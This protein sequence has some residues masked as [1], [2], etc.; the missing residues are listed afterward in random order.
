VPV[1]DTSLGPQDS[2]ISAAH[3][4]ASWARARRANWTSAPV[5]FETVPDPLVLRPLVSDTPVSDPVVSDPGVPA[6]VIEAPAPD[7]LVQ[8]PAKP[9]FAL[10]A[11]PRWLTRGAVAAALLAA[12]VVG[13]RFLW[14]AM[15][16]RPARTAVVEPAKVTP[17][18]TVSA[19]GSLRVTST[20]SG[21]R[22]LV[23][24]KPRGV[25]PLSLTDLSPGRHEVMLQSDVGSVKRTVT[26]ATTAATVVDEAIFSG[27][28]T[29]YAP[30]DVTVSEKG[31]VLRAD[32]RQ[33]IMLPPGAHE[34]RVFNRALAY[35]IVRRVEVKPGEATNL[36]LT[37]DPS[38][39][40]ITATEAAEVW[41]D[42]SRVGDTPLNAAPIPLG[43]HDI[44]VKRPAGGERRF[45]V[46]V[47]T[48]PVTLNVAF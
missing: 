9:R 29:V 32:D 40:T 46:T 23:D 38:T 31:R 16:E 42:G 26:I 17:K 11:P 33:Q 5:A 39:L 14:N 21:A 19:T 35:D 37:P 44:V 18:P 8:T 48:K 43:I 45:T 28:I 2:L 13:G 10:G 47:G 22:V 30:F 24:G 36:Q 4:A 15:P 27:F 3:A 7:D 12:L 1:D 20:P 34:L 41:V 6:A 25:T